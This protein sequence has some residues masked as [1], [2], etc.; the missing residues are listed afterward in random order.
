MRGGG[1]KRRA[2][3]DE[4]VNDSSDAGDWGNDED[5]EARERRKTEVRGINPDF[6]KSAPQ[7]PR[8]RNAHRKDMCF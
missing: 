7:V 3:D 2:G 8:T 6:S 5:P 1:R 4:F